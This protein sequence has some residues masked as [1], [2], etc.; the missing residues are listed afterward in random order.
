MMERDS[1][2]FAARGGDN[3]RTRYVNIWRRETFEKVQFLAPSPLK[4]LVRF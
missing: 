2:R 1:D 3:E 4:S